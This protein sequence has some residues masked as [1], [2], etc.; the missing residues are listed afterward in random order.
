MWSCFCWSPP[1]ICAAPLS[2]HLPIHWFSPSFMTDQL[3]LRI[4]N[5]YRFSAIPKSLSQQF[6]SAHTHLGNSLH[7]TPNGIHPTRHLT[8]S[9]QHRAPH[10][11]QRRV[12][13]F[14]NSK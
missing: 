5:E 10:P 11:A 9:S 13:H 7:N 14:Q 1:P 8:R 4:T 3:S 2:L 12:D 6:S